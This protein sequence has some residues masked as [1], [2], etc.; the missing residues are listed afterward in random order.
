[1]AR[2]AVLVLIAAAAC[3]RGETTPGVDDG[4]P[5]A[6]ADAVIDGNN[7]S[8]QCDRDY[9]CVGG[10]GTASCKKYCTN[11]IDCGAPR[12]TCFYTFVDGNDNPLPDIPKV[13]TSNCD[14][15]DTAAVGC[16]STMKCSLFFGTPPISDCT[17]A[18]AGTNG[19]TCNS[20]T[21]TALPN[22]CAKG[23]TCAKFSNETTFACRRHCINPDAT[24]GANRAECTNKRCLPYSPAVTFGGVPYGVCEP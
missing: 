14:P 19:A 8:T 15:I 22:N 23:Y 20:A 9:T 18:G 16:P 3:A 4:G 2:A 1:M 21:N 7:C 5:P 10:T 12:G 6:V 13:C 11:D 24:A 17:P